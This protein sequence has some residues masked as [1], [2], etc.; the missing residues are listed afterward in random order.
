METWSG[1]LRSSGLRD[2]REHHPN[3]IV[4]ILARAARCSPARDVT[5]WEPPQMV[6]LAR[7]RIWHSK[8]PI[9]ARLQL[10]AVAPDLFTLGVGASAPSVLTA[11]PHFRKISAGT[12]HAPA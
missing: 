6:Q 7:L 4:G 10:D 3:P 9:M 8:S 5:S 12:G 2:L 1:I 11:C